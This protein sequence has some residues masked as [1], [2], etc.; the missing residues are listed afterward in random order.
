M[1]EQ[2]LRKVLFL[3][4]RKGL[5]IYGLILH[6][7]NSLD[8]LLYIVSAE[9]PLVSFVGTWDKKCRGSETVCAAMMVKAH[10]RWR[11]RKT[12]VNVLL[13]SQIFPAGFF[14][15]KEETAHFGGYFLPRSPTK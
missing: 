7:Q 3:S 1:G 11:C 15:P 14:L 2:G 6:F 8:T 4:S 12:S 10:C 5:I 13:A 9:F